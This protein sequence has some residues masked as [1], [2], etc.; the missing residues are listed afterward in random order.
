MTAWAMATGGLV[1]LALGL[2]W[3]WPER[4]LWVFPPWIGV[5]MAWKGELL[6]EALG[7]TSETG[8]WDGVLHFSVCLIFSGLAAALS[9]RWMP[10]MLVSLNAALSLVAWGDA[11][12]FR[13]FE[14]LL[15]ISLFSGILLLPT[16]TA[17]MSELAV[18]GD[19]F[20]FIDL[21]PMLVAG[22]GAGRSEQATRHWR[23]GAALAS[24]GVV[25]AGAYMINL[26]ESKNTL[27]LKRF[28]N[29]AVLKEI[30]FLNYHG[31]DLFQ[32]LERYLGALGEGD[33]EP[34]TISAMLARSR[35][36]MRRKT[37]YKNLL[38]G[39]NVVVIQLESFQD[40]VVGLS[41][42]RQEVTPFLNRLA[43]RSLRLTLY[44]QSHHG[45]SSDGEFALLNSLHPPAQRPLCFAYPTNHFN[46]LPA[47]LEDLGYHCVYTVPYLASFWNARQMSGAYGFHES[48]FEDDLPSILPYEQV[49]WGMSDL[50]LFER[51]S[52]R[53]ATLPQPFFLYAVT[54]SGHHPFD[55]LKPH[56]RMLELSPEWED[57]TV[58]DYLQCCRFRDQA[59]EALFEDLGRRELLDNTLVILVGDHDA[60][61]SSD[62]QE[63]LGVPAKPLSDSVPA[64]LCHPRLGPL[65]TSPL[66][67]QIDLAPTLAHLLGLDPEATVFLGKNVLAT[68]RDWVVSRRGYVI[69]AQGQ[70]HPLQVPKPGEPE[71]LKK[72]RSELEVSQALLHQDS[73]LDWKGK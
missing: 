12:Y 51:V 67:G 14:D 17:S 35:E 45:R 1:I 3:R 49:G 25:L 72:A 26:P 2:G 56:Q 36:S 43:R 7:M 44:D 47:L 42:D 28:R 70:T 20:F 53:L 48:W 16:V 22:L 11:L 18:A 10:L 31:Y 30:G 19:A 73:V 46:A 38:E 8:W 33:S 27:L 5:S 58:G 55:E 50:A 60:G 66:A 24:A 41:V 71:L 9:F 13:Y 57:E 69:G 62:A 39:E 68:G 54:L 65:K 23:D 29:V 40:F 15:S 59:L 32:A 6:V 61:L 37:P 63:R 34:A 64:L 21:V 4:A 52:T